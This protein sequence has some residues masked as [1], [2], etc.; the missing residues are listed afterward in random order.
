M[1]AQ[2]TSR[3]LNDLKDFLIPFVKKITDTKQEMDQK[4]FLG[5]FPIERQKAF[6]EFVAKQIGYDTEAGR[7]DI[8]THP[9][10]TSFHPYDARITTRY[11]EDDVLYSL[12]STI[13]ETGHALYEQGFSA[14]HF[15]TP[16]AESISLGIHESQS[17]LWENQIGKSKSFWKHFYPKLQEEF[18]IPFK[19]IL[20]DDFYRIY[21]E[22][23]PSL[24]RTESDEVTYNLHIILRYEIE[25]EMIEGAIDLKELPSV[26]E[27][28][29]KDYFGLT[30]PNDSVG[31]LQDVHW[32]NGGIGYFPTYSFGNLYAAQ[33]FASMKKQ[34]PGLD[35][36][37]ANGQFTEIREWLRENVHVHG[38]T[39]TAAG[40]IKKISGEE[41]TSFYFIDYL[42][43]KYSEIYGL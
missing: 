6:N 24:I 18:P 33:L 12:G 34:I 1:T 20:P 22:V 11:K 31:V 41:L 8:S 14:E 2:E 35:E 21:N 10:S 39:Y 27:S 26:W 9:F 5:N 4:K 30:V 37:I 43:K 17:R 15:G 16:L 28:K 7:L 29:M 25:K 32:S 19:D 42:E 38:K 23:K 40:L 36:S 13:H 3:I